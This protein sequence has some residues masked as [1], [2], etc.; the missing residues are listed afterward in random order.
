MSDEINQKPGSKPDA[1]IRSIMITSLLG[2]LGILWAIGG[3]IAILSLYEVH[4]IL[5][6]ISAFV[7][8]W[9]CWAAALYF[10]VKRFF[11]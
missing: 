9:G 2:T 8:V 5:G 3:I 1:D 6:W 10:D 7:W 11:S 4:W